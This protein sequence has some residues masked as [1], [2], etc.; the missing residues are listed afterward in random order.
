[1]LPDQTH[2]AVGRGGYVAIGDSLTQG[3]GDPVAGERSC[4]WTDWVARGLAERDLRLRGPQER[5]PRS[6]G[7]Q[8]QD[9][10]QPGPAPAYRN[11]G[12][13]GTSTR[14]LLYGQL[15]R[16]LAYQPVL[17]TVTSGANDLLD[18]RWSAS[19]F[20][21]DLVA[22]LERLV[23][24]GAVAVAVTYPFAAEAIAAPGRPPNVWEPVLRGLPQVN[25][26]I[27]EASSEVGARLL[28]F[29]TVLAAGGSASG[30][31]ATMSSDLVHPNA[32]GYRL[33]GAWALPR[34]AAWLAP[35][36]G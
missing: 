12:Q 14:D 35:K 15:P 24:A 17:V 20:R 5:G 2:E 34:V 4:S 28:D 31:P 22:V 26:V 33:L 3:Y 6:L 9:T 21:R 13:V 30:P 19:G 23:E 36:P 25:E 16:A 8:E 7:G 18:P 29:E 10:G 27:R 32:R 1:M 11:L